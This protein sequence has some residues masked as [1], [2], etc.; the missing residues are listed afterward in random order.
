MP[1]SAKPAKPICKTLEK[2]SQITIGF[3]SWAIVAEAYIG[4]GPRVM[5]VSQD[6]AVDRT[7]FLK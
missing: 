4:A 7:E 6:L 5:Q 2:V 1:K 3:R